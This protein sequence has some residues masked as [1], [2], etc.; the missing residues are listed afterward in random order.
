LFAPAEPPTYVMSQR[1]HS[2]PTTTLGFYAK[3]ALRGD[4][5]AERLKALVGG[6]F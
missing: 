3:V 4:G 2:D 5:E 6:E 1:R